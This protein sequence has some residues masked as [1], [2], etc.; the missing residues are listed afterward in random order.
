M[1]CREHEFDSMAQT[2]PKPKAT[3]LGYAKKKK[4]I[5]KNEKN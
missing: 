4:K 3:S 2:K 1:A 5:E